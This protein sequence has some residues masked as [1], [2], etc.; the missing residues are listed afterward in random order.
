MSSLPSH[1][2]LQYSLIFAYTWSCCCAALYS[3]SLP[4]VIGKGLESSPKPLFLFGH[5]FSRWE[6]LIVRHTLPVSMQW[7]CLFSVGV[8]DHKAYA[9]G[10]HAVPTFYSRTVYRPSD[11]ASADS[12]TLAFGKYRVKVVGLMSS[13]LMRANALSW[14]SPHN[15]VYSVLKSSHSGC[16]RSA[17]WCALS[18][19]IYH[20]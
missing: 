12:F 18:K 11:D 19:L 17:M 16:V 9:N 20:A 7:A 14:A 3:S 6:S 5:V 10:F 8:I 15:H 13:F 1:S 4:F 2:L